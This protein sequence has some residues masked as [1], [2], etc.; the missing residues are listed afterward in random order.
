LREVD[1]GNDVITYRVDGTG[2]RIAKLK[3]GVEEKRWTYLSALNVASELDVPTE[4]S[5]AKHPP[6]FAPTRSIHHNSRSIRRE[7]SDAKH[8]PQ[9]AAV[10]GIC[11]DSPAVLCAA[12]A[13]DEPRSH[14][15]GSH[16]LPRTLSE[17]NQT[18]TT[19]GTE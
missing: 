6:Q 14:A 4:A 2:R 15:D 9:F 1:N 12:A 17:R 7:A 11:H 3:N 10:G 8:P 5:D 19:A 18:R 16:A 13:S